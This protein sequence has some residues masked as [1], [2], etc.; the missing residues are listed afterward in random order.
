LCDEEF[1]RRLFDDLNYDV[2]GPPGDSKII[3]LSDSDEEE[4]EMREAKT[5][6]IEAAPSSAARSPTSTAPPM[7][8]MHPQ[9]RNT[10]IVMITPPIGRLTVAAAAETKPV[11]LRLPRQ[12]GAC[13]RHA[14]R[15][16]SRILHCYSTSPFM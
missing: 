9:G 3:I 7:P 11:Y 2:L 5:V 12:D 13:R 15:R 14:S 1:V 8:M 6:G 4:E 16:T 10:I